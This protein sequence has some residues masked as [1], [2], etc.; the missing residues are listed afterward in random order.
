MA[1]VL[2]RVGAVFLV[3]MLIGAAVPMLQVDAAPQ[4]VDSKGN[5]RNN[6]VVGD[7]P[8]NAVDCEVKGN[9]GGNCTS[10]FVSGGALGTATNS[11]V[12]GNVFTDCVSSLVVGNVGG[13]ARNREIDG[14]VNGMCQRRIIGG[15]VRGK[16]LGWVPPVQASA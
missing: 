12:G 13:N 10:S 1:T 15:V 4:G 7:V 8:G 6:T 2:R 16:N 3:V 5:C 14:N 9:V 11:E